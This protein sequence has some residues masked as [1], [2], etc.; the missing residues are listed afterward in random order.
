MPKINV[1][2]P[3]ELAEAV[4]DSGVPVSV[5]C[6]RALEQAVRQVTAVRQTAQSGL[7]ADRLAEQLPRFTARA[8]TVVRLAIDRAQGGTPAPV[9]SADLLAGLLAEG[10]NLALEVL[11]AMEID[12]AHVRRELDRHPPTEAGGASADG[13]AGFSDPA[14]GALELT[15]TEAI[16]LG[17]NYVGCEHLLLGLAGE[18]DGVAG[19][20]L[21]TVGVEPRAARRAVTA[22]LAGYLHLRAQTAAAGTG[23]PTQA[24]AAAL[25]QQLQPLVARVERLE[26]RL[27]PASTAQ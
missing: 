23:D 27:G 4:R 15:M 5:I 21:R 13:S 6:Q 20:V 26:Q 16:T 12:P 8:H 9:S 1:Y 24:L 25:H 22:A 10:G 7:D 17:H 2:L 3:D 14:T 11:R 18:P 19:R